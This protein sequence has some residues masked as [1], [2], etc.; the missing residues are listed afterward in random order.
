VQVRIK[1]ETR[2]EQLS[3]SRR[4]DGRITGGRK[5][6]TLGRGR[7]QNRLGGSGKSGLIHYK[8]KKT[9]SPS[10]E[11]TKKLKDKKVGRSRNTKKIRHC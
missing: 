5:G 8:N 10:T 7:N 11:D 2:R 4:T 6:K 9:P 1:L 3:A